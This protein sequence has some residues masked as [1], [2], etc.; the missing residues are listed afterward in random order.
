ML[1]VLILTHNESRHLERCLKSLTGLSDDIHIVDSYSND[2]TREIALRYGA[3]F[4]E[5]PFVN[6]A[7]QF[8]WGLDHCPLQYGWVM[9][10][11]ADEY[12]EPA[13]AREIAERLPALPEDVTGI[14]LKRKVIFKGKWIRHGGFYPHVL[15]RI[16]KKEAG[17]MEQR[18]MDEHP[19]LSHGRAVLFKEHLVDENLNG[20]Q[21]WVNKHNRYAVREMVEL[22]NLKYHFMDTDERLQTSQTGQATQTGQAGRKRWVKEH[23]YGKLPPGLRSSLYFGYRYVLRGGF[24]DGYAGFVFHFMQGFWYRLLVDVNVSEVERMT[25]H[26]KSKDNIRNILRKEYQVEL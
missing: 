18:W 26:D 24:L 5:H 6:H 2:D 3:R 14:Y 21:W 7:L 20:I 4:V 25:G 19:V 22:L 11:D 8:Q 9:K 12:V 16:W 23:I 1:S 17:S 15:L 13:L 10:M